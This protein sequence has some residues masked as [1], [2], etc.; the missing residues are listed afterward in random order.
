MRNRCPPVAGLL[1]WCDGAIVFHDAPP[2][3]VL[4]EFSRYHA[5]NIELDA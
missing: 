5:V 3:E 4:T 2:T 1:A